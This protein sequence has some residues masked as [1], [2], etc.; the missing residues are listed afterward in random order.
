MNSIGKFLLLIPMGALNLP[1]AHAQW[2]QELVTR[3]ARGDAAACT[4]LGGKAVE[5]FTKACDRG[6]AEGC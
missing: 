3:C 6:I 5:L 1:V 2:D 4:N